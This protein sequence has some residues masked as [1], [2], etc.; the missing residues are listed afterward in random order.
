[1]LWFFD[2][3]KLCDLFE[4][5]RMRFVMYFG[6]CPYEELYMPLRQYERRRYGLGAFGPYIFV[7]KK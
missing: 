1:M 7:K 6:G 2:D 5:K 3:H 4:D